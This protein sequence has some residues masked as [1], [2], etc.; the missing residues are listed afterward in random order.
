[1]SEHRS[2]WLATSEQPSFPALDQD[3]DVDVAVVGAG[4]TGLTAALLLQR[5]GASV[6]LIEADRVGAGTTGGTTGK[7]TAQHTLTYAALIDKHGEDK[8]RQYA[9]ANL[10]AIDT[11]GRL[12]REASA[13]C[14]L[15]RAPAFAYTQVADGRE[16]LEAEHA[17]AVR[18]GLPAT[19]TTDIDLPFPVELALRFD[20]QAHFHPG[21]YTAALA[22]T[23][24]ANG[25]QIF[26][27]T[28]ATDVDERLDHAMVRTRGGDI[29]AGQVV[30]ATL[31][32]F[33]D[34]GGFFAKASPSRAY[35]IAA[36]LRS[37]ASAGMHINIGSPTRSTRPWIDGDRRGLIVVGENHPTGHGEAGPGKWGALERWAREHFDVESFEYRWSAQDYTTVDEI[38]YV[39]R[40]PRMTRT[41][42]A[43]GFKK[44]GLTNGTA[45]AQVLTDLIAGRDNPWV[46]VFDATRIGDADT[47]KKLVEENVHVGKRFVKDR[48]ARLRADTVAHLQP[49]DGGMVEIDGDTVGAYRDATGAV[50]AVSITCTHMGCT[51]HWNGAET[52]WDCPCHGS[53][54]ATDGG[55][56]NGPAVESLDGIDV[57]ADT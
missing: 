19:L 27:H 28:R 51:L 16:R 23:L 53:R 35:G 33:V 39:G 10:Q 45:A 3:L 15:E 30:L 42:V 13:D 1:M 48:V 24:A 5:D 21:R 52:S 4:I 14:Q 38:P 29:R 8:A 49:G 18:L 7:V 32:P 20:D 25:A 50:H 56:L 9:D 31:L 57:D 44:W 6:A 22:R 55:V 17:A 46:Q 37:D 12:A 2:V 34:L 26:E 54:F 43:T 47:V 11:I 41:F 40:S 36:R